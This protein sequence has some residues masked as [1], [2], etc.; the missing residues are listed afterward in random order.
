MAR[1]SVC[2][3]GRLARSPAVRRDLLQRPRR[4]YRRSR[5]HLGL[6]PASCRVRR[7]PRHPA[8]R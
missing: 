7:A 1:A 4:P 6:H 3:R 2:S 5:H 8:L